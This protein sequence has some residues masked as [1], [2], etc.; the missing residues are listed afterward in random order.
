MYTEVKSGIRK[1]GG[2]DM[3]GREVC[4]KRGRGGLGRGEGGGEG[5]KDC[6]CVKE[7]FKLHY[8]SYTPAHATRSPIIAGESNET[9]HQPQNV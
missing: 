6:A 5:V 4:M 7:L 3:G 2:R 9:D 8:R 1:Q